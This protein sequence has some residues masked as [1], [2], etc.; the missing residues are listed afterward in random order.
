MFPLYQQDQIES[1]DALLGRVDFK[2]SRKSLLSK[3]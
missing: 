1:S 3:I 2:E